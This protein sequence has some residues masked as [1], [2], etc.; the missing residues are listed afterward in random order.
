M[1]KNIH[2]IFEGDRYNIGH[3]LI[4]KLPIYY[5]KADAKLV[6]VYQSTWNVWSAP[7]AVARGCDTRPPPTM[8]V[9][10][11]HLEPQS[12][13]EASKGTRTRVGPE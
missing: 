8:V 12:A 9:P 10:S 13:N 7:M 4:T 2:L 5:P 11:R 3:Y 1:V 6:K